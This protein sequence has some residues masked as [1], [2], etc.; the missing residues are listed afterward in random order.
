MS[1]RV[2]L[3]KHKD[4]IAE[5]DQLYPLRNF[6]PNVTLDS[7]RFDSGRRDV[8]EFLKRELEIQ[9]KQSNSLSIQVLGT[10]SDDVFQ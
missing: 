2:D 8:V 3:R 5:L 4:L 10:D 6:S 7:I 1:L 9:E